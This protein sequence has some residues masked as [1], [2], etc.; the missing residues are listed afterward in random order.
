MYTGG[1]KHRKKKGENDPSDILNNG[2][3][4]SLFA[5]VANAEHARIAQAMIN[6]GLGKRALNCLFEP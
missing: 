4:E 6:L 1:L 2:G 5:H 3:Q